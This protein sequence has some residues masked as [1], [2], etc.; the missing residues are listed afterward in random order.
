M[1]K[2]YILNTILLMI[3]MFSLFGVNDDLN[4]SDKIHFE[5][6]DFDIETSKVDIK[7]KDIENVSILIEVSNN[8]IDDNSRYNYKDITIDE[9]KDFLKQ[10]RNNVKEYFSKSNEEIFN[11]IDFYDLVDYFKIDNYAPYFY[12]DIDRE[13]TDKDIITL[14]KIALNENVLAIYVRGNYYE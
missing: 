5:N 12:A 7:S 2:L 13:L 3:F 6:I 14:N 8:Y 11:E 10:H 1:R 9:A 4:L